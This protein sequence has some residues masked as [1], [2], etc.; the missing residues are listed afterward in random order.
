[1]LRKL[2]A[3]EILGESVGVW[4]LLAVN[5][6]ADVRLIALPGCKVTGS[7]LVNALIVMTMKM[8]VRNRVESA[9]NKGTS[10]SRPPPMF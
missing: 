3:G 8:H 6:L 7:K 2:A 1:M 4:V 9:E 10:H 5:G